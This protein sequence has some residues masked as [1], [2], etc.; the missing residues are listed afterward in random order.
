MRG[1]SYSV[2]GFLAVMLAGALSAS[3]QGVLVVT[4]ARHVVPLPRPIII[5]RPTPS[6]ATYQV[7]E[8]SV[9]A[10][11][12]GQIAKVNVSQTFVNTGSR[13]LEACFMFPL[14][15]D[16]AIDQMTLMV[17]GK[18]YP[19]KLLPKEQAR[20]IYES[21]VRK[22]QD[23]A[24]LEWIGTGMF[25]TSVFPIPAGESRQV[26]LRYSQLL[27][28]SDRLTEFLFPL[29]G[30]KYTS[31]PVENL[32]LRV[33]IASSTPIKNIYSP[34]H[35]VDIERPDG[36]HAVVEYTASNVV[37]AE[38]FRLFYDAKEGKIGAGVISYR[39]DNKD[40]GYFVL[41]ASP[42]IE[43]A[44]DSEAAN[45]SVVF[46]VDRSGSM[47]GKKME[48]AKS[49]LEFVLNNL[50]KGDTFNI[51]AYD[52]EV[53]SFAPEMQ[54]Y[55]N[56]TRKKALG[57]VRS[58]YAGGSTNI[59]GALTT[60]LNMLKDEER[61]SYVVFLT[62]GLPTAGEQNESKLVEN[63]S[64]ANQV[65]ARMLSFGVGYDVNSRLLD[66]LARENFGQSGYARPDE[67]IEQHI[68]K[69]YSKIDSPVMTDISIR[70][71]VDG[72]GAEQAAV[73]NRLYPRKAYDL[74]AGEQLVLVG[75]YNT[76]GS[77]KIK[78]TGQVGGKR[79]TFDFPAKLVK[80]SKDST[81]AFVEKLWAVRRVGE[82]IDELDLKGQNEELI[83]ELVELSTRHGI[84]TPYTS[85]LADD[86]GAVD[87]ADVRG[88]A[89]RARTSLDR[90]KEA[91]GK[92]GWSQRQAKND[93]QYANQAPAAGGFG[94]NAYRA[95]DS[96]EMVVVET[97]RNVGNQA[98]YKRGTQ[99][100]TSATSQIDLEKDREKYQK[101]ERY[102]DAYFELVRGNTASENAVLASQ[103]PEEELFVNLR[104]QNYLIW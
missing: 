43:Q 50:R 71:D 11:I 4:D 14:P 49:A 13:Q 47:S 99:W 31:K 17:N 62:D 28:K 65:R 82:I 1:K 60:A 103:R 78:I 102:S 89:T 30:A 41:L 18:E 77:A 75:R 67:D 59:D 88:N 26:T 9:G 7:K 58:I 98:L 10:N 22:N 73:I 23:P 42:E 39:P 46:V 40:D 5:P 79:Q 55:D 19:A 53:E 101:V 48:Q 83:E 87:L 92:A 56:D 80:Q 38:D 93:L 61:P 68:A 96:D 44:A 100:V 3:A 20:E 29:A 37:P 63:A 90:L 36:K 8:L 76:P 51:V 64:G 21:I 45:K 34:T 69:L 84:L 66:R 35:A 24:L 81:A 86:T 16:G 15:Y 6:P 104:G 52:S 97:L 85:F 74:F 32:N 54:R 27:R 94:G 70:F 57:F 95:I 33:S 12:E 72:A 25:Q 91:E 2:V